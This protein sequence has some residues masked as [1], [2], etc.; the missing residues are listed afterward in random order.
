MSR[1]SNRLRVPA[2]LIAALAALLVLAPVAAAETK[3]GEATSPENLLLGG[4]ADLLKATAT[5]E[6]ATGTATFAITTRE[7]LGSKS[8]AD[9]E[10]VTYLAFMSPAS[11]CTEVSIP[12]FLLEA[13]NKP[14]NAVGVFEG[15][16]G[17][18]EESLLT[19]S[20][21]GTTMTMSATAH[22]A[23]GQ[24]FNCATVGAEGGTGGEDVISSFPLTVKAEPPPPAPGPAPAPAPAPAPSAPAVLSIAKPKALKLA[25]G[26]SKA[27]RVK[28]SN[29]GATATAPGSL[30]VKA[31]TGV[32]V[33][34]E[35]QQIPTL[36]P[37]RSFS[38]SVRVELTAK[39]KPKSTVSL[40]GTA[41]G[42]TAKSS[43]VVKLKQ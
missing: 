40:T 2:L 34:P 16:G 23:V 8:G 3:F 29:T 13:V 42:L 37:G 41:S 15:S 19:P 7:A 14:L 32:I 25:V 39:A 38:L 4:E 31:P 20:L 10:S 18:V 36:G 27:I 35:R 5:Y 30:R 11:P 43:L 26:E 17:G 33:K 12:L 1:R 28:V 24:N 21:S 9:S 22:L 6:S